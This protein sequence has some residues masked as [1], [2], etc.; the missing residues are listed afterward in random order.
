M[1]LLLCALAVLAV[2]G[3]W[4]IGSGGSFDRSSGGWKVARSSYGAGGKSNPSNG[5]STTPPT[6]LV[7]HVAGMVRHPGVYRLAT[8]SRSY[9]AIDAAGGSLPAGDPNAIDLAAKL[10]DGLQ[11]VV[12]R[13]GTVNT[14][15]EASGGIAQGSSG[16]VSLSSATVEQLDR[17]DGI[18]P[19]LAARIVA[20]RSQHGGFGSVADLDKVPGIGPAKLSGLRGSLVP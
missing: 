3:R 2:G 19:A 7:V 13:R 10:S 6:V 20:W 8:G 5:T 9:E 11:L 12:P 1:L 14:S 4:L 17:L 15:A 16:P 18:G